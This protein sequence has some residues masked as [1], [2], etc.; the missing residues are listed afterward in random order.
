[1]RRVR[2]M[3]VTRTY[4]VALVTAKEPGEEVRAARGRCAVEKRVQ[5]F[6]AAIQRSH[7]GE[8]IVS[9]ERSCVEDLTAYQCG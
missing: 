1:M 8:L 3:L 9:T 7:D 6:Q 4:R 5:P 2:E